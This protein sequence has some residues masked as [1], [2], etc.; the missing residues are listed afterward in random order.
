MHPGETYNCVMLFCYTEQ[1]SNDDDYDYDDP[2]INDASS[3]DYQP[4][5]IDSDISDEISSGDEES[6]SKRMKKE[7]KKFTKKK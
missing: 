6:D 3:D 1:E 4:T 2:F 5:D 7:A